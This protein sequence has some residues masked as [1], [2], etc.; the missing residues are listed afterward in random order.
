MPQVKALQSIS[1]LVG[2]LVCLLAAIIIACWAVLVFS[3]TPEPAAKVMGVVSTRRLFVGC[4]LM[5]M[6]A[7][8]WIQH[9]GRNVRKAKIAALGALC[10]SGYDFLHYMIYRGL[11]AGPMSFRNDITAP[12]GLHIASSG[13]IASI[14]LCFM[15][16]GE[17]KPPRKTAT[18]L[19]Y[20]VAAISSASLVC[21][22]LNTRAAD[23]GLDYI[24]RD[25][26]AACATASLLLVAFGIVC[27]RPEA[28]FPRLIFSPSK[29]GSMARSSRSSS[30]GP[31]S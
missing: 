22:W 27:S 18:R 25:A 8:L 12:I 10:I 9:E 20:V 23:T 29:K 24:G 3:G 30:S 4:F 15:R 16:P 6:G 17:G 13:M 1:R 21:Q 5:L 26:M 19:A 31:R 7:S 28:I 11:G 2:Q 14:A